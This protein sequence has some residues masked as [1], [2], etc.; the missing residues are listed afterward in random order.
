MAAADVELAEQPGDVHADSREG[1]A[2]LVGD[3][4]VRHAVEDATDDL[5][6]PRGEPHPVEQLS[7]FGLAEDVFLWQRHPPRLAQ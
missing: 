2:E 1:D 6:L 7:P 3:L 4:L 5:T